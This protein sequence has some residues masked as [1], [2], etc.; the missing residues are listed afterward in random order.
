VLQTW[1]FV[2]L[3]RGRSPSLWRHPTLRPRSKLCATWCKVSDIVLLVKFSLRRAPEGLGYPSQSRIRAQVKCPYVSSDVT[4]YQGAPGSKGPPSRSAKGTSWAPYMHEF[5]KG[6]R[7]CW[8]GKFLN[9]DSLKCH[10]LDF[11]ERFYRIL[12]VRK[13]HCD[14][15]EALANVFA[16]SPKLGGPHLAHWGW[17][18]PGSP[19][20]SP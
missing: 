12:M 8:P 14:I 19:G 3:E 6:S 16:L 2:S 15:S 11:G 1:R 17:G 13:R 9:L 10:F 7:A 4:L 18:P 20:L 5:S